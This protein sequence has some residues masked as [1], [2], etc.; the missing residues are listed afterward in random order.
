MRKRNFF[1]VVL[2]VASFVVSGC[3]AVPIAGMANLLHKSGTMTVVL[4]GKGDALKVFKEVAVRNGGVATAQSSDFARA[5]FS[6]VDMKI[7]AQLS[8]PDRRTLTI[9]GSSLSNVGR[10]I[11][12]KDNIGELTEKIA[13]DMQ[14]AGFSI[15]N[16]TRDRGV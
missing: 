12:L 4:Q 6:T 13:F 8:L 9:R 14:S 2:V 3:V 7:E 1:W 15:I 16:K 5:E 11:E 10:T